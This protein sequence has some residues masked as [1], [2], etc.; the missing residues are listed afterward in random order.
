MLPQQLENEWEYDTPERVA[1]VVGALA[2]REDSVSTLLHLRWTIANLMSVVKM[3]HLTEAE[4]TTFIAILAPTARPVT[5]KWDYG[6][7]ERVAD[8]VSYTKCAGLDDVLR[9][10]WQLRELMRTAKLT[11][12]SVSELAALLAVLAAAN[13]RRL[14]TNAVEEAFVPI[15]RLVDNCAD[16][17][18]TPLEFAEQVTDL[19]D[20]LTGAEF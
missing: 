7:T 20:E 1:L 5:S 10:R 8:A 17:G 6:V 18:H 4:L 2:P 9:R 15:L 19:D 16:M 11:D 3:V 12:L 14:L 13:G